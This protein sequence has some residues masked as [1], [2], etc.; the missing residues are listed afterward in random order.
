MLDKYTYFFIIFSKYIEL[1]SIRYE[2]DTEVYSLQPT[3]A[4]RLLSE[5]KEL[6][7]LNQET[8]DAQLTKLESLVSYLT[9]VKDTLAA[10]TILNRSR[11][12]S[13]AFEEK[14]FDFDP[15]DLASKPVIV[16]V[17][18][19]ADELYT[20]YY[21]T[22]HDEDVNTYGKFSCSVRDKV[23]TLM[24]GVLEL[25]SG[26]L[27][28][29]YYRLCHQT[30]QFEEETRQR[31]IK[32]VHLMIE[33]LLFKV[34]N[35]GLDKGYLSVLVFDAIISVLTVIGPYQLSSEMNIPTILTRK[36]RSMVEWVHTKEFA[37]LLDSAPDDS[38]V[39]QVVWMILKKIVKLILDCNHNTTSRE[40]TVEVISNLDTTIQFIRDNTD[41]ERLLQIDRL[42]MSKNI[43]FELL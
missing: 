9:A 1:N 18:E 20:R 23:N 8:Q 5:M 6:N 10:F 28:Y 16:Q 43:L 11:A 42:S 41:L 12:N 36:V 31:Y 39:S 17:F 24:S 26:S 14:L 22:I 33:K 27:V 40:N 37:A 25:I 15:E 19:I 38:H 29:F 3:I 4:D 35:F 7:S 32:G 21:S 34:D 30:S 2:G 13:Y